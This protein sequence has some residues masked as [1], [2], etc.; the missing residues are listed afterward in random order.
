MYQT[1]INLYLKYKVCQNEITTDLGFWQNLQ[2]KLVSVT[3]DLKKEN[4][5]ENNKRSHRSQSHDTKF[6]WFLL[7]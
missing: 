1:K 3:T 6:T 4:N 5:E 7:T 2:K